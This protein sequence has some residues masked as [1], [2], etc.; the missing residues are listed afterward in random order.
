MISLRNNPIAPEIRNEIIA[1]NSHCLIVGGI[2]TTYSRLPSEWLRATESRDGLE[3]RY[4]LVS[5]MRTFR[6]ETSGIKTIAGNFGVL[7]G[8]KGCF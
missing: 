5:Q 4:S 8:G 7:R 6:S 3:L 2:W 1:Q